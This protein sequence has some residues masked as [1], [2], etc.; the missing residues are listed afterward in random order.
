MFKKVCGLFFIVAFLISCEMVTSLEGIVIY[1][2]S[3]E[4]PKD[5]LNSNGIRFEDF[6]NDPAPRSGFK[7]L[8]VSGGCIQPAA[9]YYF[10]A[11][12]KNVK[13]RLESWGKLLDSNYTAMLKIHILKNDQLA[14]ETDVL[15]N[16]KSA[17]WDYYK[18]EKIFECAANTKFAIGIY[19]GG[20][21]APASV[22][23][24]N[25]TLREIP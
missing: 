10:Q 6:V 21:V 25:L 17:K 3:F 24:D 1:A 5:T 20:F 11:P 22:L 15:I 19:V 8:K 4:S 9:I 12:N 23:I 16:V 2:N 13:Y 14:E 18:A 7:S